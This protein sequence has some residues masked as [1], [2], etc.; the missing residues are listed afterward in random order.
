ML[1]IQFRP[2]YFSTSFDLSF[3]DQT[4]STWLYVASHRTMPSELCLAE[5]SCESSGH[6]EA[7]TLRDLWELV[8]APLWRRYS[9]RWDRRKA[10]ASLLA[11][12]VR[13]RAYTSPMVG[14]TV[15]SLTARRGSRVGSLCPSCQSKRKNWK[16]GTRS[17]RTMLL[18]ESGEVMSLVHPGD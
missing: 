15:S 12:S 7:A 3:F 4:F 18:W 6:Q 13:A 11:S 8:K 5:K 9:P 16:E 1:H 10:S 17:C 2:N 14:L